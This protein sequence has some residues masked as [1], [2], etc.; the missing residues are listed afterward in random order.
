VRGYLDRIDAYDRRGPYLN[1]LIH[2]NANA[3]AEA[4]RLD[5]TLQATATLTGPL[6]G[7]PVIVKDN[8]DTSDMP[9]SSGVALFR[10]SVP[11]RDAFVV[12]RLRAAGAILLAKASL[13]ELAMGLADT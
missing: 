9:T 8:L 11:T 4:E 10:D 12:S 7:V 2:V 6:H 1:S 13:S 5:A 3:L